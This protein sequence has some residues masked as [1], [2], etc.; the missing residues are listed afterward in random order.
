[1]PGRPIRTFTVLPHLPERLQALQK[2]AYNLWWCWNHEAVALFARIDADLF[3]QLD[4]SPVKLLGAIDQSRLEQLLRD[5]G[6]LAHMDRVEENFD[7]YMSASTWYQEAYAD[8]GQCRVAYFSAE[9]GIH[10]SIPVYSGGLG[11]LAGDHLKAASD[12]G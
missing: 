9:F 4:Y 12:L 6:F 10:E 7:R 8:G 2:L 3:E 5:D 11:V 1:M